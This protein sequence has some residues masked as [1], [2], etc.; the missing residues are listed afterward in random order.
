MPSPQEFAEMKEPPIESAFE[1]CPRC[2]TRT[3]QIGAVP[4]QCAQCGFTMHFGPVAAVGA[5][6]TNDSNELLLVRRAKEPRKGYWGL[7]GG[8]VDRS[9]TVEDAIVREVLEET[10]L[11]VTHMQF[12][13]SRPN[14][15]SYQGVSAQVID[16][17]FRC[18]VAP[19]KITFKDGELDR[20]D[21]VNPTSELFNK[22]AFE[23]NRLA[24]ENWIQ[25][26]KM[27]E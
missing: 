26:S 14:L 9:E 4:F 10:D 1:F 23:S 20:F 15:Y 3:D 18:D 13:M 19:G 8:F 27:L 6:V 17:F 22:M 5:L 2:A 7:P 24:V 21:W 16:L 25:E 11:Q 12:V